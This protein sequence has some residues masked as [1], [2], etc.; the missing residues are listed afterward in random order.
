MTTADSF[1]VCD[2]IHLPDN[3]GTQRVNFDVN[4]VVRVDWSNPDFSQFHTSR[5][6]GIYSLHS[7]KNRYLCRVSYAC[8]FLSYTNTY[9]KY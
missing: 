7:T 2:I 6:T 1:S 3:R 4:R 5:C 8:L 9:L